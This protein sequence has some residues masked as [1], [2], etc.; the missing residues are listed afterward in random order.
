MAKDEIKFTPAIYDEDWELDVSPKTLP[1]YFGDGPAAEIDDAY[2]VIFSEKPPEDVYRAVATLV[3]HARHLKP[4]QHAELATWLATWLENPYRSAV[5]R[6]INFAL[7]KKIEDWLFSKEIKLFRN[8]QLQKDFVAEA[9]KEFK[10]SKPVVRRVI[11]DLK[12][13]KATL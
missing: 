2:E 9:A 6:P 13:K 12:S 8:D 3:F 1:E 5:G 4:H 10:T 7:R 11:Q